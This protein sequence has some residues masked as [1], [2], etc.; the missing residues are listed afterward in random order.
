[1]GD[2]LANKKKK[3]QKAAKP[4]PKGPTT[5]SEIKPSAPRK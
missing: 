1:M 2:K 3:A 5:V 4:A